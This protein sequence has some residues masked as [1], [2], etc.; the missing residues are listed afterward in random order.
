MAAVQALPL[1]NP[2]AD[3]GVVQ[4][5]VESGADHRQVVTSQRQQDVNWGAEDVILDESFDPS[6]LNE[7]VREHPAGSTAVFP[8]MRPGGWLAAAIATIAKTYA[9][10]S[11][12]TT[13]SPGL[14]P[15]GGSPP[16]S[17]S[18]AG[19]IASGVH[20]KSAAG[21]YYAINPNVLY[22]AS[23]ALLQLVWRGYGLSTD[24]AAPPAAETCSTAGHMA[25]LLRIAQHIDELEDQNAILSAERDQAKAIGS[26]KRGN[27]S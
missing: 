11:V 17:I 7:A 24:P 2:A 10:T 21:Y 15:A 13:G 14:S 4:R 12:T 9:P 20:Q 25:D 27:F 16:V 1:A 8:A 26:I 18:T 23:S 6:P 22:D 3:A 5:Y 19:A